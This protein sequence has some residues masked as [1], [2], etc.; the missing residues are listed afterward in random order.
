MY[1]PREHMAGNGVAVFARSPIRARVLGNVG[2]TG[3]TPPISQP[4]PPS[5]TPHPLE[6]RWSMLCRKIERWASARDL[7]PDLAEDLGSARWFRGL[8]TMI[9][10]GT[11]AVAFWP[12]FSPLEAAP[13]VALDPQSGTELRTMG[14]RP[15][16]AGGAN[17]RRFDATDAVI[18]LAA[19]PE[20]PSL[21]LTATFGEGDSIERML[22]R[23][24]VGVGDAGQVM[25]AV[26]AAVPPSQIAPGTRF[27]ITLGQRAA[28][29]AP[30]PLDAIR[31][32]P[33][34]DLAL[35]LR[36]SGS[37][38]ALSKVA[39]A[40]DTTP[41]RV[42]GIVGQSLYRSARAAGAP[43]EAVQD[44]LRTIDQHMAFEDIQPG[45]EFDLIVAYKRTSDGLGQAGDLQYA[46]VVRDGTPKLQL[47]RWGANGDFFSPQAMNGQSVASGGG[48]SALLAP[49]AGRITSGFGAR[50]HPILGFVR[51]HA[52]IDFA[53]PWGS[54]VYAVT[55]GRVSFAGWHGGHGNYVRLEHGGSIG[56]GYGHMSRIAV[57]PG[58]SV[59]RGQVIGYVG[60]TGL[61]TGPHLHYELYR[62]GQPVDPS[63]VRFAVR[64]ATVDAGQLAGFKARLRQV[65]AI[66]PGL[67]PRH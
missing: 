11:V 14:L 22:Q 55:D 57:S 6:V 61:S 43:P 50:R 65:L 30:R 36:R 29:A 40:V 5:R 15:L 13:L 45:D 66:H 4:A 54:P 47:L 63:S 39:I 34:F 60:S 37:G 17:G 3:L 1:A 10:L 19:A 7:A 2:A 32:R 26:S 52:G 20:R 33:R 25:Q 18:P 27:D 41:L 51:L 59:R 12:D 56:T 16:A 53:A 44:Y 8:G 23:A 64:Q 24:G 28:P 21:Q 42:R 46:G 49:V 31:F 48:E 62:G 38:F 67:A 9:A 35:D 58:M